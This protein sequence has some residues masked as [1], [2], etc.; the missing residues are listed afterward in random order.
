VVASQQRRLPNAGGVLTMTVE[1]N[2]ITCDGQLAISVEL[3]VPEIGA[4]IVTP[5]Q[6]VKATICPQIGGGKLVGMK[7]V[8]RRW[9]LVVISAVIVTCVP[10][11]LAAAGG[12]ASGASSSVVFRSGTPSNTSPAWNKL[13]ALSTKLGPAHDASIDVLLS[14]RTT[15]RPV[16]LE[17]WATAHRLGTTWYPGEQFAVLSGSAASVGSAFGVPVDSYRSRTGE[18][19]YASQQPAI[20]RL[21]LSEVTGIGRISNYGRPETLLTTS[22]YVPNGGITPT[23]LIQAYQA[24]ALTDR[25]FQ[26]QG[27]TVVLVEISPVEISDLNDFTQ[28][29]GL[30]QIQL[31]FVGGNAKG[32]ASESGEAD[33]DVETV[34]EIAPKARLVYFDAN[35]VP[36]L[37]NSTDL[38]AELA[39]SIAAVGRQFPGALVSM[40]LGACEL[41]E[42]SSDVAAIDNAANLAENTGSTLYASSGDTGGA[43]CGNF[44]ADSVTSAKGV[45]IPASAPDITGVGGTSLS[46][47]TNGG[48]I[49]ETTWSSVMMAQGG[50]GGVSTI[51]TRP[52][53]QTGPGVGGQ[54]VPDMREVPDVSADADPLTGN[55][56]VTQGKLES[57]GGTSL[58]APIWAGFTALIDEFLHTSGKPPL[59]FANPVFYKLAADTHLS[60]P[61]FHDVTAGGNVFYQAG[62]G[63]DPVTGLG[64]PNVAALAQALLDLDNSGTS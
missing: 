54:Q 4:R 23:G 35:D 41:S 28:K 25:G 11:G 29:F 26:G 38:G 18:H 7:R 2:V 40:S 58:S 59:G 1:Q 33:M 10:V 32:A 31:Q 20:P 45:N 30:P 17:N 56:F 19:F 37:T 61:P 8:R 53:W 52:S 50:A 27:E 6:S 15:D 62:P 55:A 36:G 49:G 43:D 24:T 21:L 3:V 64:T 47:G 44:G 60:P 13:I 9:V 16:V 39:L 12:S 14:L 46:V 5:E 34:H 22:D 42:D 51:A 48:Y 57:G 63:Y